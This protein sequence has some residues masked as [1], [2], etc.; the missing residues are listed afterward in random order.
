[1]HACLSSWK[2]I[3]INPHDTR[4][5]YSRDQDV[6]Q[7]SLGRTR[8]QKKL[9]RP[10]FLMRASVDEDTWLPKGHVAGS[11]SSGVGK[12]KL[13]RDA[14]VSIWSEQDAARLSLARKHRIRHSARANPIEQNANRWRFLID[15]FAVQEPVEDR[16]SHSPG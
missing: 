6:S 2:L 9:G 10:Q 3:G 14:L 8:G 12:H 5:L 16:L 11:E 4:V 7:S 1:M 13:D 15:I